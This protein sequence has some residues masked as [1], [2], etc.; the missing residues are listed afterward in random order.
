MS[1]FLAYAQSASLCLIYIL[2]SIQPR[3]LIF[4]NSVTPAFY[5]I[6]SR[7]FPVGAIVHDVLTSGVQVF[8]SDP[9]TQLLL[10]VER[11]CRSPAEPGY[12]Q[13]PRGCPALPRSCRWHGTLGGDTVPL[14]CPRLSS[15]RCASLSLLGLSPPC[16]TAVTRVSPRPPHLT[17]RTAFHRQ[18]RCSLGVFHKRLGTVGEAFLDSLFADSFIIRK[19]WTLSNTLSTQH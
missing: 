18:E 12:R 6:C 3:V 1:G 13:R 5:Q 17:E 10:C 8:L 14:L 11:V 19:C 9:G 2:C 4:Q 15:P 7:L 16:S